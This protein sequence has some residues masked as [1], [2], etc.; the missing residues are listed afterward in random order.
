MPSWVGGGSLFCGQ[1]E[2]SPATFACRDRC[3]LAPQTRRRKPPPTSNLVVVMDQQA[4]RESNKEQPSHSVVVS[5]LVCGRASLLARKKTSTTATATNSSARQ[6]NFL[7]IDSICLLLAF[8]GH[9]S[10]AAMLSVSG[11]PFS[12]G[13]ATSLLS[14]RANNLCLCAIRIRVRQSRRRANAAQRPPSHN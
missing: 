12:S 5:Q 2:F 11:A 8:F 3:E 13:G 4:A 7:A 10:G 6:C 1:S 14:E 9:S